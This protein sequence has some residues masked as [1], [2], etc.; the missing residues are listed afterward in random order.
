[1]F[2]P[3]QCDNDLQ[4]VIKTALG[5]ELDI[6]GAWGYTQELA[7]TLHSTEVPLVQFQH[8]FASMRAYVE[9]NMTLPQ[10]ERHGSIN[11]TEK[12][13]LQKSLNGLIYDKVDYEVSSMKEEDY[14][15]FIAAY[16]KGY[17]TEGFDMTKHFEER[18][19]ATHLREV[20]HW[21]E[22]SQTI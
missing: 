2:E 10:E 20:T 17:G 14:K 4:D 6:S 15:A 19:E 9:M 18:K 16:K 22:V 13:R 7:T 8:M 5:T 21:F 11:V 3:L 12:S 1:M